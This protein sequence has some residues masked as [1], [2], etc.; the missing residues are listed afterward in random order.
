M[1]SSAGI[2][3][4]DIAYAR[5]AVPD[6]DLAQQFLTDFGLIALER[7]Q[8][9]L[10]LRGTGASHHIYIAEQADEPRLIAFGFRAGSEEDLARAACLPDA[11]S[12]VEPTGEPGGGQRVRLRE[13]NGYGIEIVHDIQSLPP[14][15][16]HQQKV[17]SAQAPLARKG[18]L[19]RLPRAQLPVLRI[20]HGIIV[21]PKLRETS[22]WFEENLGFIASDVIYAGSQDNIIGYFDRCDCGPEYVDHHTLGLFDFGGQTGMHHIS[23]EV[24][25]IDAVMAGHYYLKQ[26]DRY[27]HRWG[28]GRHTSGSQVFDYWADPW[29][30]V[31]ERWADSD[32]LNRDSGSLLLSVDALDSQWGEA[33][34]ESFMQAVP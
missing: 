23:F 7:T 8:D 11:E 30:R 26:L 9:K 34:P 3:V 33:Q 19:F 28:V 2:K 16:V 15:E 31:H 12:A 29:G 4:S 17:N 27:E 32:R 13:P 24:A 18:E 10:F 5:V 22:R 6:L 21:T 20:A 25:D 1:N 14:L